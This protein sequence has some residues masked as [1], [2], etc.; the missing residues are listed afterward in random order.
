VRRAI[1]LGGL[2]GGLAALAADPR[3]A[4]TVA[5]GTWPP[6]VLVLG[7]VLIGEVGA[8]TG[9]FD[10]AAAAAGR[11]GRSGA[12]LFLAL[13]GMVAATSA[14]LNLDTAAAF[15]TPV[16]VLA[17]R[18][19]GLA[20]EPFLYGSLFMA[21]SASLLLPGSNLTN[22]LVAGTDPPGGGPGAMVGAWGAAVVVTAGI[23]AL[24]YRRDL[25]DGPR[26]VT[27]SGPGGPP[28]TGTRSSD[29]RRGGGIAVAAGA[30]AAA[31]ALVVGWRSPALAVLGV[32]TLAAGVEAGRRRLEVATTLRQLDL[33]VLGG[34]FGIAVALATLATRW[35][36]LGALLATATSWETAGTAALA[37]VA[38][39][40]LPA[41]VLLA[42]HAPAHPRALLVGL[43]VGPNLAV[44]GSLASLLWWKAA[45]SVGA[46]PSA[47][48]YSRL[49]LVLGPCAMA[50]ALA[51][52][53]FT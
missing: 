5:A 1:A 53:A 35:S 22:L 31:G 8:A 2:T 33:G 20:E 42:S 51:A 47:R 39:N 19:R 16:L 21:N 29:E 46:S 44:T 36:G 6:F 4:A 40:N 14:V 28:A 12:G 48:T 7:L 41:A 3:V 18:R 50:A 15:L 30:T 45:R 23:L 10:R 43:D 13:L 34:L 17:A 37:A 11:L 27:G 52:L 49:G 25:A 38:V 26:P 32:G 24:R 9:L